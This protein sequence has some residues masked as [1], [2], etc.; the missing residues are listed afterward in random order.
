MAKEWPRKKE[1]LGKSINY[2]F[3][4][5]PPLTL[6]LYKKT[7]QTANVPC[8]GLSNLTGLS[9]RLESIYD[10]NNYGGETGAILLSTSD[11]KA[12]LFM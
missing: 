2:L 1:R 10:L 6:L 4:Q 11:C 8:S 9:S 7:Y 3:N 5:I 12:Y